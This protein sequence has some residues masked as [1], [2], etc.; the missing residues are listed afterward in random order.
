MLTRVFTWLTKCS[1][2]FV[3]KKLISFQEF[4]IALGVISIFGRGKTKPTKSIK[5]TVKIQINKQIAN[6]ILKSSLLACK[7]LLVVYQPNG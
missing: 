4:M 2:G 1:V 6:F 3:I 5:N 7:L